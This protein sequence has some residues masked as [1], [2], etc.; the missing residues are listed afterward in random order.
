MKEFDFMKYIKKF[1]LP[2]ILCSLAAGLVGFFCLSRLQSYTASAIIHYANETA[3]DGLA[4]DGTEI[5]LTEIYSSKVISKTLERMGLSSG[6][7]S[8]DELR[9]RI[10]VTAVQTEGQQAVE[11]AMLDQGEPIEEQPVDYQ[12][13]FTAK[14]KD[15]NADLS[16]EDFAR[17]F[18]DEML[19]VYIAFYGEEHINTVTVSNDISGLNTK[20][21]DYLEMAEILRNSVESVQNSLA[22]KENSAGD[23]R[24]SQTGYSFSD[25]RREFSLLENVEISNVFAYILEN[26]VTKNADLLI[27]KYENR[28]H[29]YQM[30]NENSEDQVAYINR[31]ID[32]YVRMMRESGNTNITY[33]Y[34]LDQVHDNFYT[35]ENNE[36]QPVDQTVEYDELLESY[37]S[38]RSEFENALIEIAYCEYILDVYS[39]AV[40][41]TDGIAVPVEDVE[42]ALAKAQDKASLVVAG[43]EPYETAE[44]AEEV[45]LPVET[46]VITSSEEIQKTA[47]GMIDRLTEEINRLY[48]I[49]EIVNSEYNEYAGAE[50]INMLTSIAVQAGINILM[51]TVLIVFV[52]GIVGCTGAIVIGRMQD[53]FEYYV[54]MDRHFDMPNR[55]ACDRKI[56]QY[57][58][59][60]LADGFVC[61]A[62]TL[63]HLREKNQQYG[64]KKTDAM[65]E[66][67]LSMVKYTFSQEENSFA[68]INGS[69]Q[70]LVFGEHMTYN[71]AEMYLA[72]LRRSV[73]E[74]NG[75]AE[76]GIEFTAGI[77]EAS[78][79]KE[80]RMRN[81]LLQALGNMS[82]ELGVVF[83]KEELKPLGKTVKADLEPDP[84]EQSLKE[85]QR[86]LGK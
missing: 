24:S 56:A 52:F 27:A 14:K 26:K 61:I 31:I 54:Y 35:D 77:A 58:K 79:N 65:I 41:E 84:V 12:V 80:Y 46:E 13:S 22:E 53:I 70:F 76:C 18:L 30:N 34:I 85:L 37:I 7:Y 2:I 29:E 11:A 47:Q 83:S 51:Y 21:Y 20:N 38:E 75:C 43:E 72:Q 55:V 68:G 6:V 19:D 81:L 9:S 15:E 1:Q 86:V 50:N 62:I 8:I 17:Q 45:P 42:T 71:R 44:S 16:M 10:T 28:I 48:G 33:E 36:P 40:N 3:V 23:F 5:D 69:G 4:P 67:F 73:A 78:K 63:V 60:L 57:E 74:Y 25:L 49:L 66:E 59:S 82:E 39:G 64:R 32:T